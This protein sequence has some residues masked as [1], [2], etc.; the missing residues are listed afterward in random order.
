[1]TKSYV[2]FGGGVQSTALA[3]MALRGHADLLSWQSPLP[4]LWLFA[5][6]GDEPIA[7]YEHV[8]RMERELV[9]AGFE[10]RRV[11]AG[12]LSDHVLERAEAGEGGI[13][14]PPLFVA[15]DGRE[16]MPVRR[17]CTRDFKI[18]PLDRAARAHFG[19]PRRAQDW[20]GE[21]VRQWYGISADEGQRMRISQDR[22]RTFAYPLVELGWTRSRCLDYLDSIGESAPRSA[23]VFC[24][25]HSADEWR[26]VKDAP[27]DW[28][29][30]VAFEAR[31]HAAHNEHGQIAGL[32]T[33]PFLHRS[34]VPLAD[35]EFNRQEAFSFD[36]ECAGVCGI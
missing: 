19:V 28:A 7:V 12:K 17:G 20:A 6:T 32:R 31:L 4:A 13:S 1:M 23:C 3:W 16:A 14:L 26:R 24:P 30:A 2:S 27:G 25:F 36:D 18:K 21:P 5:D 33:K 34:R 8:D 15:S 11:S 9:G 22:W 29:A 35:V 10:F